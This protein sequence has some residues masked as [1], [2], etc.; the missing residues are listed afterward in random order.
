MGILKKKIRSLSLPLSIALILMHIIIYNKGL[1]EEWDKK[2]CFNKL[3]LLLLRIWRG[4]CKTFRPMSCFM[5]SS[6]LKRGPIGSET[7]V[8]NYH[9]SLRSNPEE[10]ISEGSTVLWNTR[11]Y[12]PNNIVS[13]SRILEFSASPLSGPNRS[14]FIVYTITL[15]SFVVRTRSVWKMILFW[16]TGVVHRITNIF[17]VSFCLFYLLKLLLIKWKEVVLYKVKQLIP[18]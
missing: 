12:R 1:I 17:I 6:S 5:N 2:K 15:R 7:S 11:S 9:C 16:E 8:R 3:G 4:D 13:Y 18:I 10:R 14:Y